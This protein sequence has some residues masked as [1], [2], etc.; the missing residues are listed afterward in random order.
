MWESGLL[1]IGSSHLRRNLGV[2][3]RTFSNL[4]VSFKGSGESGVVP[5]GGIVGCGVI[6]VTKGW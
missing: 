3:L 2:L 6:G 4:W 5:C 1:E